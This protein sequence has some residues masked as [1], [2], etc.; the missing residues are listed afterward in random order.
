MNNIDSTGITGLSDRE[1]AE[2]RDKFGSNV[3]TPKKGRNGFMLFIEH[4]KDPLITILIIAGFLSIGISFYRYY[5]LDES[6][7]VFFEPIGIFAAVLL[8]AGMSFIFERKA[9]KEFALLNKVGDGDPVQVIRNGRVSEVPKSDIVVGDIVILNSGDEIPADGKLLSANNMSVDEST[10][11]GEPS[12]YKTTDPSHFDKDATFPSDMVLRG[13]KV[14]EGHGIMEVKAVGDSTENGKLM[15]SVQLDNNVKTPLDEQLSRLGKVISK[16]SYAVGAVIIVARIAMYLIEVDFQWIHFLAYLL[17]TI[18][19]AVTLIVVAVPEGLPMAVTLSLAYSMRRMLKNNNLVRKLHACET[20]GAA[21]VICTDKT[22]TLTKNRMEVAEIWAP[23]IPLA[24]VSDWQSEDNLKML[25]YNLAC[26]STANLDYSDDSV[27]KVVGNPTEGALI[28]WL[29]ANGVD[30]R[31]IRSHIKVVDELSFTTELKYMATVIAGEKGQDILLV[32]GAPEILLN[33][34]STLPVGVTAEEINNRLTEYQNQAMR[35]LAFAYTVIP[36]GSHPFVN[37]RLTGYALT[38]SG[39]V[40]IS[41]PVRDD[42]P[43]ALRECLDAGINVKI[44]TGDTPATA[45]EIGRRV[46]LWHDGEDN[47]VNIATG[48]DIAA[49]SDEELQRRIGAIKIVARARPLDKQRLVKALQHNGEIV[50]VTGDGTNDA[51]ALK[52]AHVG[53]AMG[54]GT[55]VAKEAGDITIL[56]NSF[57]SIG[58]AVM[59][60]R[61]LY[62]NIQRFILFQLTVNLVASLVVLAGAF[63]G[64][65]SPITITQM[66]WVN[67]VMDTVAAVAFASLPPSNDVMKDKPRDRKAFIITKKMWR[68]IIVT[69]AVFFAILAGVLIYFEH[70]DFSSLTALGSWSSVNVGLDPYKLSVFFT[71]FVLLNFWNMF[72]AEAFGSRHSA[73]ILKG[74]GQFL[75]I[76]ACIFVGQ[77][78]VVTFGGGFFNVVPLSVNDWLIL[79]AVTSL[80]A[81]SGEVIR[82]ISR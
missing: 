50:A 22:G 26:N 55:A 60:G 21:T 4:L 3:I 58:K 70:S 67:L 57:T 15:T 29:I 27:P 53:L 76:L 75:V 24:N 61:S 32:K 56:D 34:C 30:Y 46:G 40:A 81:V 59:W 62:K 23:G 8:A 69:G 45:R 64:L 51:P 72:N 41:D 65:D 71:F 18:M 42:V 66:L 49:M 33:M 7:D 38:L 6:T 14:M 74:Y 77:I 35:T 79:T 11:T 80:V 52:A 47:D 44:V 78:I 20:M 48:S 9:D 12:A 43:D 1:V 28:L 13:T 54:D 73:F 2:S 19:L 17:Q 5:G 39:I 31:Q 36:S 10:L 82:K 25:V 37:G 16:I 63:I 68:A